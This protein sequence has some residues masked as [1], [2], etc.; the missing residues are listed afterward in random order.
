M[1]VYLE[2]W[3]NGVQTKTLLKYDGNGFIPSINDIIIG[4]FDDVFVH[5]KVFARVVNS[6]KIIV[7]RINN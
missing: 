5:G 4:T 3:E 2:I 7:L 6:S 1:I